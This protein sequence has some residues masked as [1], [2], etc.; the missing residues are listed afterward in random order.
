MVEVGIL[1]DEPLHGVCIILLACDMRNC[2]QE[3]CITQ[4]RPPT[5]CCI[6]WNLITVLAKPV[7]CIQIGTIQ[8]EQLCRHRIAMH[9]LHVQICDERCAMDRI[10]NLMTSL[11]LTAS[12]SAVRSSSPRESSG[13]AAVAQA[14]TAY[15]LEELQ[16]RRMAPIDRL[17]KAVI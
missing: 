14:V 10:A 11:A 8:Y 4:N 6:N 17:L 15:T 3:Q 2:S 1:A 16:V 12:C 13:T 7:D 5:Q 9:Q